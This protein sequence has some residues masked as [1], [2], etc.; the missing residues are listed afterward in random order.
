MNSDEDQ[1]KAEF[2]EWQEHPVTTRLMSEVG[3]A[4][5]QVNSRIIAAARAEG[6]VGATSMGG[7]SM[8]YESVL[9]FIRF[10]VV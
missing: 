6:L 9:S 8:A 2:R 10:G 1:Q 5:E 3:R 7:A 4:L